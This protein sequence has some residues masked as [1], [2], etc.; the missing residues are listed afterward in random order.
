MTDKSSKH[1]FSADRPITSRT[2][3]LLGVSGFA[4]SLASS[5][6][7]LYGVRLENCYI[8]WKLLRVVDNRGR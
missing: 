4:E 1:N 7:G 6:K 5:I 2:E 3:D 8:D